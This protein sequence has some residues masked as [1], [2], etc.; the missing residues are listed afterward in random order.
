MSINEINEYIPSASFTSPEDIKKL[1][2]LTSKLPKSMEIF[3]EQLKVFTNLLCAILTAS[4]PLFLELKAI[5]RSL[6]EYKPAA[7]ALI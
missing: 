3:T 1:S 6:M 4:C 7:Q 2:K 5:I